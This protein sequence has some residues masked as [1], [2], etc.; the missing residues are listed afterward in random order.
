LILASHIE[1]NFTSREKEIASLLI[2]GY[3][4]YQIADL[5]FLSH[6]TIKSHRANLMLKLKAKNALHLGYLLHDLEEE[7]L[8]V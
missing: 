4:N 8:S 6:H 2:E 1:N 3:N 5:L 7:A